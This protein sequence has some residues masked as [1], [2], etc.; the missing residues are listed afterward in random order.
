MII[1]DIIHIPTILLQ[2]SGS[3]M[4]QMKYMIMDAI[5][6]DVDIVIYM[7]F[8]F[9]NVTKLRNKSEEGP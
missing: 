6:N 2:G 1:F 3:R 9:G 4:E 8:Q 7:R 5:T